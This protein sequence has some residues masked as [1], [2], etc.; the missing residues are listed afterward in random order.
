MK[1]PRCG[2]DVRPSK[3]YPGYYLCDSCRKRYPETS[4]IPDDTDDDDYTLYDTEDAIEPLEPKKPDRKTDRSEGSSRKSKGSSSKSGKRSSSGQS[5]SV[6]KS[7]KKKK[8]L[9]GMIL[10]L[11]LA[12][13]LI[14]IIAVKSGLISKDI[15]PFTKSSQD[16]QNPQTD[17]IT[18]TDEDG[19]T[20]ALGDTATLNDIS[21]QV[22]DYEESKG[23]EWASPQEGNVF[24]F[25]N[26]TISNQTEKDITVSSMASFE[27]YC[28]EV[29]L[30]YSVNAFT[31]L[32]TNTDRQQMDGSIAPGSSLNGYLCLEVPTDWQDLEIHY[33]DQIWKD[34]GVVFK[35]SK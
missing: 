16:S 31:A 2:S 11:L 19:D 1:C 23:D 15:L 26:L 21:I 27:S 29:K 5:R 33:T 8:R 32:A 22:T 17:D 20:Y 4:L 34:E 35:I 18:E 3:K 13:I 7:Q 14:V 12:V 28:N 24:V 9:A 10:I 25:V 30:D 6:R